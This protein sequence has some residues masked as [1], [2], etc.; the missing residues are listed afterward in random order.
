MRTLQF[1]AL[2]QFLLRHLVFGSSTVLAV[3]EFPYSAGIY[4]CKLGN[5]VAASIMV[6]CHV[7]VG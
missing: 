3:L 7:Q 4:P 5:K 2:T 6:T 1:P